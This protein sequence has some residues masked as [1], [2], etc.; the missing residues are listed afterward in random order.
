LTEALTHAVDY[1]DSER[2]LLFERIVV[3]LKDLGCKQPLILVFDDLHAVDEWSL[4]LLASVVSDLSDGGILI[5]IIYREPE[6]SVSLEVSPIWRVLLAQTTCHL[7]V[8]ELTFTDIAK[9]T[10][11]LTFRTPEAE[12]IEA[13]HRKTGGNPRLLEILLSCDLVDWRRRR[14]EERIPT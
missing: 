4:L 13:F 6:M 2:L 11:D 5:L 9:M 3:T 10:K 14:V 12:L 8:P 7:F 1:T